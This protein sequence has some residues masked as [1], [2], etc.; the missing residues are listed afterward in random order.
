LAAE[1]AG[2]HRMRGHIRGRGA[3]PDSVRADP[4]DPVGKPEGI[5]TGRGGRDAPGYCSLPG[6]GAYS[7]RGSRRRPA[8]CSHQVHG[9]DSWEESRPLSERREYLTHQPGARPDRSESVVACSPVLLT[10]KAAWLLLAPGQLVQY[11]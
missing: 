1:E 10:L 8:G 6:E 7:G 4:V 11:S 9:S 3:D 5:H 2:Q